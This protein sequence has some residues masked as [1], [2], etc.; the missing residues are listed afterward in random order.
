M[1]DM[2]TTTNSFL[3]LNIG[4]S[5]L[6]ILIPKCIRRTRHNKPLGV[7]YEMYHQK[8]L[9]FLSFLKGEGKEQKQEG[10]CSAIWI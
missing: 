6:R 4:C 5:V 7:L 10:M 2:R 1:K 9:F 8:I 3:R